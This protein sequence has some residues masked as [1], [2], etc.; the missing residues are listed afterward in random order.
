MATQNGIEP[1]LDRMEEVS[2]WLHSDNPCLRQI[3]E[4]T[5]DAL[6]GP[7]LL[8]QMELLRQEFPHTAWFAKEMHDLMA[9]LVLTGDAYSPDAREWMA[10]I[11]QA[12]QKGQPSEQLSKAIW[13]RNI[14]T[15]YSGEVQ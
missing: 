14:S 10:S 8:A 1:N 13:D 7:S 4:Q 9:M 12:K 3:A 6:L 5:V 2:D 15:A 11:L